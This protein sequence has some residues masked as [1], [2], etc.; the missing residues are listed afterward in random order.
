MCMLLAWMFAVGFSSVFSASISNDFTWLNVICTNLFPSMRPW[1]LF[2]SLFC[3]L[4]LSLLLYFCRWFNGRLW[5]PNTLTGCMCVCVV[6]QWLPISDDLHHT[7]SSEIAYRMSSV[8]TVIQMYRF[9]SFS[10]DL[11]SLVVQAH[12][13][14]NV[15]R[16][17]NFFPHWLQREGKRNIVQ[18]S[19]MKYHQCRWYLWWMKSIWSDSIFQ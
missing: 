9:F 13:Q 18:N 14:N 16:V 4:P 2:I 8:F 19:Y 15:V 3:F 17:C 5:H 10:L 7:L 11:S 12:S 6:R 1:S